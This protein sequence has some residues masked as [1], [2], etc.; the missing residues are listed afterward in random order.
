MDLSTVTRADKHSVPPRSTE[1]LTRIPEAL[2]LMLEP[3]RAML[4]DPRLYGESENG[5]LL[6]FQ[7]VA[8][9]YAQ[10]IDKGFPTGA[11]HKTQLRPESIEYLTPHV[12]E[13]LR[14]LGL[15]YV[16]ALEVVSNYGGPMKF[17][18][19]AIRTL[20]LM[21]KF[22]CL[23][24]EP[25]YAL[26]PG[27]ETIMH[28][29]DA[30]GIPPVRDLAHVPC[31]PSWTVEEI[32]VFQKQEATN[33]W[34]AEEYWLR[35]RVETCNRAGKELSN[36]LS[37]VAGAEWYP[38]NR[39]AN[40]PLY[41]VVCG[42]S[43]LPL[44]QTSDLLGKLH[45]ILPPA[46]GPRMEP[47]LRT[48][49]VSQIRNLCQGIHNTLG[50][51]IYTDFAAPLRHEIRVAVKILL[52]NMILIGATKIT[53]ESDPSNPAQY[54]VPG[55][56]TLIFAMAEQFVVVSGYDGDEDG[57]S[58]ESIFRALALLQ[59]AMVIH[60]GYAS[61]PVEAPGYSSVQADPY[62]YGIGTQTK[63]RQICEALD[64]GHLLH[65]FGSDLFHYDPTLGS[66]AYIIPN[67]PAEERIVN[68]TVLVLRSRHVVTRS[69]G[70]DLP[71]A[72]Q[73]F[74]IPAE[75]SQMF[76]LAIFLCNFVAFT[77]SSRLPAEL[78]YPILHPL[79][80][81]SARQLLLMGTR[82]DY[83]EY[84]E[85]GRYDPACQLFAQSEPFYASPGGVILSPMPLHTTPL[86]MGFTDSFAHFEV[87]RPELLPENSTDTVFGIEYR[88]GM[89][90]Y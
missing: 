36:V 81:I 8:G 47:G 64:H 80:E 51:R 28:G 18:S 54:Y 30:I 84:D 19:E 24:E 22:H 2:Q 32:T 34:V 87:G 11:L 37:S 60:R 68:D 46:T 83:A 39:A 61:T 26:G 77:T 48:L 9:P 66:R 16:V 79:I 55:F 21:Q 69:R 7:E 23:L 44:T 85:K 70:G 45:S 5:V 86:A 10:L 76:K 63:E 58:R 72:R 4:P 75:A 88:D 43:S 12:G 13:L 27:L 65:Q 49:W 42:M 3:Y 56:A 74:N 50:G 41:F 31:V 53:V 17:P 38:M 73:T 29:W 35:E 14:F 15:V 71:W 59:H 25:S 40:V 6:Y 89:G 1:G 90:L 33:P 57:A 67:C 20:S 62:F 82:G 52:F 78:D